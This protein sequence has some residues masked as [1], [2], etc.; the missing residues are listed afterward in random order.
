MSDYERVCAYCAGPCNK[1]F[2]W[3]VMERW[4][5]GRAVARGY[6]CGAGCLIATAHSQ[7]DRDP[8]SVPITKGVLQ[9]LEERVVEPVEKHKP[10]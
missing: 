9:R 8:A 10:Q 3:F 2:G 5:N 1:P 6:V 4:E 7:R